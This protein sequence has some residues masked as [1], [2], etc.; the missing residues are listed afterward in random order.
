[1]KSTLKTM[2]V[3]ACLI[4][5]VGTQLFNYFVNGELSVFLFAVVCFLTPSAI[6]GLKP[7][8]DTD[9]VFSKV[10]LVIGIIIMAIGIYTEFIK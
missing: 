1:M 8:Y 9:S 3:P 7:E 4:V 5:I 10:L 6:K 2:I